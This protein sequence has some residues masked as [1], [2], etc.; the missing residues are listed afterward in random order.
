MTLQC[1]KNKGFT[2]SELMLAAAI[3]IFVLAGL[4]SLFINCTFLNEN[5]RDLTQAVTHAEYIM[6]GVRHV[7]FANIA[8]QINGNLWDAAGNN[9]NLKWV[10][11]P[12]RNEEIRTCCFINDNEY[13]NDETCYACAGDPLRVKVKVKWDDRNGRER[14]FFIRTLITNY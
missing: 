7:P 8:G 3:L 2:L 6:E 4:L 1:N 11:V 14:R 13:V 9:I 10:L 5:N 12:L